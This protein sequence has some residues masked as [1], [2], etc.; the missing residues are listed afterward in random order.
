MGNAPPATEPGPTDMPSKIHSEQPS[1]PPPIHQLV[2]P[3]CYGAPTMAVSNSV[4][5]RHNFEQ[6]MKTPTMIRRDAISLTCFRAF[7]GP[8]QKSS[9]RSSFIRASFEVNAPGAPLP[10]ESSNFLE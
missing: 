8:A 4:Q 5:S 3:N 6:R 7:V 9:K 1:S 2:N 10:P